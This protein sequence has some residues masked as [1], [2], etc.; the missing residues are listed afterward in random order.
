[1]GAQS[2]PPLVRHPTS[3]PL[4]GS[5]GPGTGL[6]FAQEHFPQTGSLLRIATA[7]FSVNGYDAIEPFVP[8]AARIS[9]LIGKGE[10]DRQA[11]QTVVLTA[12]SDELKSAQADTLAEAV[13]DM[14]DRIEAGRLRIADARSVRPRYHCKFYIS[15]DRLAW[16]GSAN[17]SA[18]GLSK[19]AE[20]ASVV[21]DQAVIRQW[22]EWF[23]QVAAESFDLT[24][25]LASLLRGWLGLAEPFEAYLAALAALFPSPSVNREAEALEPV[26]FQRALA[27]WGLEQLARYRGALFVVST[28][29]GKTIIGA[30]IAGALMARGA[31]HHLLLV[32]PRAVHLP[33]RGQLVARRVPVHAFDTSVL[34]KKASRDRLSKVGAFDTLIER[35]DDRTLVLIDEVHEYRNQSL[36]SL[37]GRKA[38]VFER[39]QR[40]IEGGASVLLMTGSAYATDLQNLLSQLR[41]LPPKGAPDLTR[42]PEPWS[43]RSAAAF[44]ALPVVLPLGYSHV[45]AMAERRGDVDEHGPF[46]PYSN[47]P[48][49]LPEELHSRLISYAL[50]AETTATRAF[51]RGAFASKRRA[52]HARYDDQLHAAVEEYADP[53]YGT[54]L[55]AWLSSPRAFR[56]AVWQNLAAIPPGETLSLGLDDTPRPNATLFGDL[57]P[58]GRLAPDWVT[59][60]NSSL[61][62]TYVNRRHLL[63]P[64][65]SGI[66]DPSRQADDK[67]LRLVEAL[68]ALY[69]TNQ[70]IKAVV[71]VTLHE[72]AL[73][74]TQHLKRR[75]PKLAIE[76][77]VRRRKRNAELKDPHER[78]RLRVRFSPG[79]HPDDPHPDEPL[80][81]LV[82]TDADGVGV[83]LQ[84]AWVVVNYDLPAGADILIQRLGR[85]LRAVRTPRPPLT[86]LTLVPQL[87][88]SDAPHHV[89]QRIRM[90]IERL[91]KREDASAE[92]LGSG[93]L[94]PDGE[95]EAEISLRGT[96]DAPAALAPAKE[97]DIGGLAAHLATLEEHRG[98]AER[99]AA[100]PRHTSRFARIKATRLVAV[101]RTDGQARTI[102][103][104]PRAHDGKGS[105]V[106]EATLD[107]L[108]LLRCAPGTPRAPALKAKPSAIPA[109]TTQA[110][111]VW[112]TQEDIDPN[113]VERVVAVLLI[114][115]DPTA[116]ARVV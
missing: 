41:L 106:S 85:I 88:L 13:E 34:F 69:A 109:L 108:D 76:T 96:V 67:V 112:C 42:T 10:G 101:F 51:D 12:V 110:I 94:P 46:L 48:A 52:P 38:A 100:N 39:I 36:R 111:K 62:M 17:L 92:I 60:Y 25:D 114:P 27:S 97:N 64:V 29:L 99:L 107:A 113:T 115:G 72:T 58:P 11:V 89:A 45:L 66:G 87:G 26:Y 105:I 83:N 19:Q 40:A 43:A 81:V 57:I 18:N 23:D 4:V 1:M 74:V 55:D 31:L 102:V 80:D 9:V 3:G 98:E 20:Q 30:E 116:P 50:P 22:S 90:R 7:Y 2:K 95:L 82:C 5:V 79:S 53:L 91:R 56:L 15:S 14:I 47:G 49:Y 44:T 103:F 73:H 59:P 77:T 28:G 93:I 75:L 21:T 24:E 35:A 32:A 71:F 8:S 84:D 63:V 16:H 86:L 37:T 78:H 65:L 70:R 54:A 61:H 68:R 104:D 6:A 33:W